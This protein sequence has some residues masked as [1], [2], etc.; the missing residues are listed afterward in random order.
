[1][2]W[3]SA[4]GGGPC[5]AVE[6][7]IE[8]ETNQDTYIPPDL[9][10]HGVGV[11]KAWARWSQAGSHCIKEGYKVSGVA[12]AGVGVSDVTFCDAFT[13]GATCYVVLVSGSHH[14]STDQ[15]STTTT[16]VRVNNRNHCHNSEDGG[17]NYIA[18]WGAI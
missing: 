3:A 4:G 10:R 17:D 7:A 9:L 18:V 5:Q 14:I 1:M 6:S 12:D 11:A 8:C 2:S 13:A 15:A 16:V